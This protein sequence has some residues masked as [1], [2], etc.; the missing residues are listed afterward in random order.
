MTKTI[1]QPEQP[2]HQWLPLDKL[3]VHPDVQRRFNQK[4][5]DTIAAKFDPEAFGELYVSSDGNGAYF[6]WDGQHRAAAAR[7]ALGPEQMVYCRVHGPE[8][9]GI[10]AA[11]SLKLNSS[12]R[13]H[14]IDTFEQRVKANEWKARAVHG[15]LHQ[16]GLRVD[17]TRDDGVV[18]AVSACDW[19]IE[20]QGGQATFERTIRILFKA[21][22]KDSDAYHHSL[23]WGVAMLVAR[24]GSLLD[25]T[26]LADKLAKSGGPARMIGRIRDYSKSAFQTVKRASVEVLRGLYNKGKS[27]KGLPP[28]EEQA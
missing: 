13:W 7:K 24:Y 9:V 27:R 6:I 28:W 25:D 19:I 23:L 1:A 12:K 21:W 11:R 17:H 8:A 2:Q 20:T 5:A 3:K 22:E 18:Q 14:P 26:E 10:L 4:W 15:T 16:F